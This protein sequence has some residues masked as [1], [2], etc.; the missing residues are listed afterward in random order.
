M[1]LAKTRCRARMVASCCGRSNIPS[2]STVITVSA[3]YSPY[4]NAATNFGVGV[5][6]TT[7][8][9]FAIGWV[10]YLHS[11]PRKTALGVQG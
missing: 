5:K 10:A 2:P 11:P 7:K 8:E 1:A 4:V 3:S 9:P 6:I